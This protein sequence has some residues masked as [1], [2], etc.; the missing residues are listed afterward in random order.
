[1]SIERWMPR[2]LSVAASAAGTVAL[3]AG[4]ASALQA[5]GR[6]LFEWRGKVDREVRI[7]MRGSELWTSSDR[8]ND[9]RARSRVASSLPQRDGIVRVA[10]QQGRGDVDVIQQPARQNDYTTVLR[11]RDR[12]SGSSRYRI[13]AYWQ[14]T[15][16]GYDRGGYDRGGYDHGGYDRGD[17]DQGRYDQRI[18]PRR[19]DDGGWDRDG[20]GGPRVEPA[21]S[22]SMHW[23][24]TVDS[25]VEIRV[26]GR[27]VDYSTL[28]GAPT[29][30]ARASVS[31]AGLSQRN[32]QVRIVQ[33]QGR[34][35]ITVVQ[36]PSAYNGYAALI[37][38]RDPQG[39]YGYY[40]FDVTW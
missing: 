38:V 37:R 4:T 15:A 20:V 25:D 6:Q 40:N 11:V 28:S 18:D 12:S 1:M 2:A 16:G 35:S 3:L 30:D 31:G 27:R 21:G 19:R 8:G 36:Q 26:Q 10:L 9:A 24:G 33:A 39:G 29:R 23:S 14:P 7:T 13:D 5:Q 32:E 34:G 22:G 17:S